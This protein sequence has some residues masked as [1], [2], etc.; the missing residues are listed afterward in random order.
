MISSLICS[1][2]ATFRPLCIFAVDYQVCNSALAACCGIKLGRA[3]VGPETM[4]TRVVSVAQNSASRFPQLMS[5]DHSRR[6]GAVRTVRVNSAPDCSI[7][8][9]PNDFGMQP[10]VS[11]S[12]AQ[13]LTPIEEQSSSL[14]SMSKSVPAAVSRVLRQRG[15]SICKNSQRP[16][17]I[18]RS[19]CWPDECSWPAKPPDVRRQ[20]RYTARKSPNGGELCQLGNAHTS[21]VDSGLSPTPTNL[22]CNV[23]GRVPQHSP[24]TEESRHGPASSSQCSSP[25]LLSSP[26]KLERFFGEQLCEVDDNCVSEIGTAVVRGMTEANETDVKRCQV[27][28]VGMKGCQLKSSAM[29]SSLHGKTFRSYEPE[30][31]MTSHGSSEA[32]PVHHKPTD[33]RQLPYVV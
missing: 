29:N 18:S 24:S 17:P 30:L 12:P 32:T 7:L 25:R 26:Y 21:P 8:W 33:L 3:A 6:L 11:Q 28:S 15:N 5:V 22:H 31:F 9:T 23:A 4:E 20:N 1:V 14:R 10:E 16:S 19:H 27:K 13:H 2:A